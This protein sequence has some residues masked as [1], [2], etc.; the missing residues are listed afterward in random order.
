MQYSGRTLLFDAEN[1]EGIHPQL[2]KTGTDFS[3]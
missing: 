1:P 3:S 2:W